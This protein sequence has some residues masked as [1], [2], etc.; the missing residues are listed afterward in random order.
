MGRSV[1]KEE[2]EV[3]TSVGCK[4]EG[5][6]I[7]VTPKDCLTLLTLAAM[8]T[9][10]TQIWTATFLEQDGE[11]MVP[12]SGLLCGRQDWVDTPSESSH[13]ATG[14]LKRKLLFQLCSARKTTQILRT[15][16]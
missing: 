9:Q 16:L 4:A 6:S 14:P 10:R 5:K 2:C 8:Y 3:D 12:L 7:S 11:S 1:K 13:I 15:S